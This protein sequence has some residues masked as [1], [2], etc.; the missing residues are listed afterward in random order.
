MLMPPL[1]TFI[2]IMAS[3]AVAA[4]FVF[5]QSVRSRV[6]AICAFLTIPYPK[7]NLFLPDF[8]DFRRRTGANPQARD[9]NR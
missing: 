9:F 2:A 5:R 8:L 7:R 6:R 1:T 4:L 3:T